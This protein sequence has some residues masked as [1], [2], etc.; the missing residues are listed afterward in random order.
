MKEVENK[1]VTVY[2]YGILDDNGKITY[3]GKSS[4]PKA[5]MYVHASSIK[6]TQLSI[7]I[8]DSFEDTENYWIQRLT[9]EGNTLYNKQVDPMEEFWN[10]GD[11]I[12]ISRRTDRKVLDKRTGKVYKSRNHYHTETGLSYGIIKAVLENPSHRLSEVYSI[13]YID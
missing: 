10:I 1:G 12:S 2:V 9:K 3:V 8:L 13:E 6:S 11:V 5:R 7:Q 4:S